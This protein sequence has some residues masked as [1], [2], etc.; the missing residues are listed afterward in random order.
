MG[1]QWLCSSSGRANQQRIDAGEQVQRGNFIALHDASQLVAPV[2]GAPPDLM[3]E[4]GGELADTS[5]G[6][7]AATGNHEADDAPG[8]G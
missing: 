7:K 6:G 3:S 2:A 1:D 4:N 8:R 5:T